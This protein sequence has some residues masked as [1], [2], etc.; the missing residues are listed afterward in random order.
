MFIRPVLG[1]IRIRRR[2][3]RILG[4]EYFSWRAPYKEPTQLKAAGNES[5]LSG[6]AARQVV[7]AKHFLDRAVH[8]GL[9]HMLFELP[10]KQVDAAGR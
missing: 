5:A 9:G 4:L 6:C 10:T 3:C 7:T 8:R 1:H 2:L